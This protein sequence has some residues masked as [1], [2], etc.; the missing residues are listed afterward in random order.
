M[1]LG[2]S[3]LQRWAAVADIVVGCW[4]VTPVPAAPVVAVNIGV[5]APWF[6]R[7]QTL[8]RQKVFPTHIKYTQRHYLNTK[9]SPYFCY[10]CYRYYYYY[11][12]NCVLYITLLLRLGATTT[13]T[14]PPALLPAFVRHY[15]LYVC[16]CLFLFSPI[17]RLFNTVCACKE[18]YRES[19]SWELKQLP[20]RCRYPKK[21]KRH[22][23]RRLWG[24]TASITCNW[25]RCCR[26][27]NFG[28][29]PGK[30]L[31]DSVAPNNFCYWSRHNYFCGNIESKVKKYCY[32][33]RHS[34]DIIITGT[35]QV[36]TRYGDYYIYIQL[37]IM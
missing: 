27:I 32:N 29:K 31:V 22:N 5:V 16:A 8:H 14:T 7:R 36:K 12:T 13:T 4:R 2:F 34:I 1:E 37:F 9:H 6:L 33:I 21:N 24:C 30:K 20:C 23:P 11:R 17:V 15:L 10:Y 25:H 28:R 35:K 3:S 19:E 26:S 18:Q